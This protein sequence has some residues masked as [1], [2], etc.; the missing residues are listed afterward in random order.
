[1]QNVYLLLKKK[2]RKEKTNDTR[3]YSKHKICIRFASIVKN[4]IF[5]TVESWLVFTFSYVWN[6][7]PMM[8]KFRT[9]ELIS[10]LWCIS[11]FGCRPGETTVVAVAAACAAFI[12]CMLSMYPLLVCVFKALFW[13]MFRWPWG[14]VV[15][16]GVITEEGNVV[17]IPSVVCWDWL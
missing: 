7:C 11:V 12:R 15:M 14:S 13:M 1:M 6:I 17:E 3:L 9:V 4:E 10:G 5:I 16:I 2:K 8:A